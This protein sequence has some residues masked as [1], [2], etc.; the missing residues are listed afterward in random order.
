MK[1]KYMN[2]EKTQW[3]KPELTTLI[4]EVGDGTNMQSKQSR[5]PQYKA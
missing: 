3:K 5:V 4:C 1:R 2:T